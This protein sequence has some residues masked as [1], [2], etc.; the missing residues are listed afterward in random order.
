MRIRPY[1]LTGPQISASIPSETDYRG[2]SQTHGIITGSPSGQCSLRG[3]Q[4]EEPPLCSAASRLR[5]LRGN[6]LIFTGENNL[7]HPVFVVALYTL[8]VPPLR[9]NPLISPPVCVWSVGDT[10][11]VS[12]LT[13]SPDTLPSSLLFSRHHCLT[14]SASALCLPLVA[15]S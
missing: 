12:L 4:T 7:S 13:A 9:N 6:G 1:T 14:P 3:R 5:R 8:S 10:V 11:T 15:S 2:L